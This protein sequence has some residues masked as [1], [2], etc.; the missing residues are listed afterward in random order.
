M[1]K[2]LRYYARF[3][4][5]CLLLDKK[6]VVQQLMNDLHG[7]V[8]D[9]VRI[10]KPVDSM[11]WQQV[12]REIANFLEVCKKCCEII[13]R[14]GHWLTSIIIQAEKKLIPH[15]SEGQHL[16]VPRRLQ[17]ERSP[18]LDKDGL[19]RL[20]LAEAIL[21]GNYQNQIKFSELTLDMYH[22]LQSLGKLG[23]LRNSLTRLDLT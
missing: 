22:I 2:K 18:R 12:L 6:E 15:T 11:E 9:F 1:I 7:F 23:D 3:I 19:P 5:V 16:S 10:F 21:V 17:I 14:T 13:F 8:N 20:K 4:V